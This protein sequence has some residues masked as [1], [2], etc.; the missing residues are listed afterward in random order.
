MSNGSTVDEIQIYTRQRDASTGVKFSNRQ[1]VLDT[2]NISNCSFT[3][4]NLKTID[5]QQF[6]QHKIN[7][8]QKKSQ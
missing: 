1:T 3:S 4:H 8:R 6:I 7:N 5:N 2:E